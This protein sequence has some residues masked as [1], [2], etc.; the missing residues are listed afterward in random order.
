MAAQV[1][2]ATPPLQRKVSLPGGSVNLTDALAMVARDAGFKLSYNAGLV[3]TNELVTAEM[4][5][6]AGD[7]LHRL[8][9]DGI[10]CKETGEHVILLSAGLSKRKFSASGRVVDGSNGNRL[11]LASIVEVNERNACMTNASGGFELALSGRQE[12]TPLFISMM[13]YSDTVVFVGRNGEVGTVALVPRPVL[14]PLAVRCN[15]ERCSVEDLGL[16]RLLVPGNQME[17]A[18][19]APIVEMRAF[20]ASVW[21]NVGTNKRMGGAVVNRISFNLLVG[22]ARGL[23]GVEVG[24]V[25]N[26]ER[27][28]VSG[29]Q[30]AG[31]ANLVGGRTSGVQ[32]AGASN[33][34]MRSLQGT[35]VAGFSNTVWDTLGGVQ[36]AGGV[37][38]VKGDMHG[39]QVAGAVNVAMQRMDGV[40]AAGGVNVA[41][42]DVDRAQFSGAANYARN[43]AGAQF[44]GGFNVCIGNAA[45]GQWAG[46]FNAARQV[47]GVQLAAGF[48]LAWDTVLGAQVGVLNMGRVVRGI[49]VGLV[50]FSDTLSG[51]SVGLLSV[52]RRGYHRLD[53]SSTTVLPITLSLRT[54]MRAFHNVL[55]WSPFVS[56]IGW[57]FGYG[58]GSEVGLGRHDALEISAVAEHWNEQARWVNAVNILSRFSIAH[59]HTFGQRLFLRAGLSCDVLTTDWRSGSGVYLSDFG[60]DRVF[61]NERNGSLLVRGALGYFAGAGVRF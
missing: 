5:G 54:G 41:V 22:Y 53:V 45:G 20:Q 36:I 24:A 57:G 21:P 9:G 56:D 48:N 34:T 60:E 30:M 8:L 17:Q 31:L 2:H 4:T 26:M 28:H 19:R 38:V 18:L 49:Q 27:E 37:N 11:H 10:R 40:Q 32:V 61:L 15:F 35:Q 42:K 13:G 43:V 3:P 55:T 16:A 59:V 39:V 6:T 51:A 52:A 29:L 58:F 14:E 12:R 25:V 33:H 50:N 46:A 23:E 1:P 44:A 7:V 47:T